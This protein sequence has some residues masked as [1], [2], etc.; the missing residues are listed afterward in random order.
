MEYNLIEMKNI[1]SGTLF[2]IVLI[3]YVLLFKWN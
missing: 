1:W 3:Y 2:P